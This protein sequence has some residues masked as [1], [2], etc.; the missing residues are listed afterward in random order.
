MS[1]W[2]CKCQAASRMRIIESVTGTVTH[3][4]ERDRVGLVGCERETHCG[5]RGQ[6]EK[7]KIQGCLILQQLWSISRWR[8]DSG[9]EWWR[10]TGGSQRTTDLRR[11]GTGRRFME[12]TWSCSLWL[13]P[14]HHFSLFQ[15]GVTFAVADGLEETNRKEYSTSAFCHTSTPATVYTCDSECVQQRKSYSIV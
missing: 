15:L 5:R 11:T 7:S 12:W 9:N 10:Q 4:G 2:S 3:A 1:V 14:Y 13:S 8:C 6:L